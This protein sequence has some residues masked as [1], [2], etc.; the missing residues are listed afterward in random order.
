MLF[1]IL[2]FSVFSFS[3][4]GHVKRAMPHHL[5]ATLHYD[6]PLTIYD[7]LLSYDVYLDHVEL[8]EYLA[9]RFVLYFRGERVLFVTIF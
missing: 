1:R 9:L 3:F 5:I 4:V 8:F 2:L 7:F 6:S